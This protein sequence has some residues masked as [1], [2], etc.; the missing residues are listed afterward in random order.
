MNKFLKA[1]FIAG[2]IVFLAACSWEIPKSISVKTKAEYNFSLG[3]I[4]KSLDDIMSTKKICDEINKNM[5]S[6]DSEGESGSSGSESGEED[7]VKLN[8]YEYDPDDGKKEKQFV[9]DISVKKIE[10]DIGEMLPENMDF[11]SAL[12]DKLDCPVDIPEVEIPDLNEYLQ[13]SMEIDLPDFS[14]EMLEKITFDVE[15]FKML[16]NPS[17]NSEPV[18]TVMPDIPIDVKTGTSGEGAE[19]KENKIGTIEFSAGSLD[20]TFTPRTNSPEEMIVNLSVSMKCNFDDGAT[21]EYQLVTSSGDPVRISNTAGVPTVLSLPLENKVI[22]TKVKLSFAGSSF[23]SSTDNALANDY[24][25]YGIDVSFSSGT[26]ISKITGVTMDLGEKGEIDI[27]D[28]SGNPYEIDAVD[29]D[30]FMECKIGEGSLFLTCEEPAGWS[31]VTFTPQLSISGG[32]TAGTG[33]FREIPE[34]NTEFYKANAIMNKELVLDGKSYEKDSISISGKILVNI[35]N[36]TFVF[37]ENTRKITIDTTGRVENIDEVAVNLKSVLTSESGESL[38]TYDVSYDLDE[39]GTKMSDYISYIE[40]E[41]FGIKLP[42]SNTFPSD[43]SSDESGNVTKSTINNIE[44]GYY[45]AFFGFG[46]KSGDVITYDESKIYSWGDLTQEERAEDG[47]TQNVNYVDTIELVKEGTTRIEPEVNHVVD[48]SLK[49]ILPGHDE[50]DDADFISKYGSNPDFDYFAVFKEIEPGQKYSIKMEKPL[51]EMNWTSAGI[52]KSLIGDNLSSS[53]DTGIDMS[54]MLSSFTDELGDQ[55]FINELKIKSL[56]IYLYCVMPDLKALQSM[57]PFAGTITAQTIDKT[58]AEHPVVTHSE[59]ILGDVT[60]EDDGTGNMVETVN[61]KELRTVSAIPELDSQKNLEEL[62]VTKEIKASASSVDTDLAG[63]INS[64]AKGSMNIAYDLTL[65]GSEEYF[66][67]TKEQFD[68]LKNKSQSENSTTSISIQARL[69]L[70]FRFEVAPESGDEVL[71]DI[72]GFINKGSED[73]ESSGGEGGEASSS[74]ETK[75]LFGRDEATNIDDMKMILDLLDS[76]SV[77]YSLSNEVLKYDSDSLSMS[78][79]M[80]TKVPA[81]GKKKLELGKNK[82]LQITSDEFQEIMK[83]YP[84]NPGLTA[85]LPAGEVYMPKSAKIAA[86]VFVQIKTDGEINIFGGEN[87]LIGG[88]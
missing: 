59:V 8:L 69:V 85:K 64:R 42:Y 12:G 9:A 23:Q 10:L 49:M 28:D 67:V 61:P 78:V 48:V 76:V 79:E 63:L 26:N 62:K 51:A 15:D 70:P 54:S 18:E 87:A 56:P 17:V 84:F 19:E 5:N 25:S 38:L 45:S 72:M 81:V 73:S 43:A 4:T 83:T 74:G 41:D 1:V 44:L 30:M 35:E 7:A 58:D 37:N 11:E 2:V 20:L 77:K 46:S 21:E 3:K 39:S 66:V 40:L 53:V 24:Y 33:D 31:G 47:S 14:S 27:L 16:D 36:A 34:S 13:K 29:N 88:N 71:I 50:V 57:L 60:S 75:D 52:K 80:D 82:E 32:I 65:G 68:E 6:S 86:E 55:N 22:S